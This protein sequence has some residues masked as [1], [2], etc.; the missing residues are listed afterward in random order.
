VVRKKINLDIATDLH[1]FG[2]IEIVLGICLY[3]SSTSASSDGR[4]SFTFAI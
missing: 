4:V 1:V 2:N 3:V